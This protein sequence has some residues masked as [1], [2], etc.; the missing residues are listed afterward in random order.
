M[1]IYHVW[2]DL[3][4][5]VRGSHFA[6]TVR[7]C[8]EHLREQGLLESW[9]LTRRKL[10]LG[11]RELGEWHLMIEVKDLRQMQ[12]LFESMARR[13]DPEEGL[14]HAMNALVVN[15]TYSLTRDYPDPG[16]VPGEESF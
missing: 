3:K 14:H 2:C 1:D 10:G 9:R 11:P 15:T 4:H 6:E 13:T 5:G 7:L 12:D 8:M 16:R